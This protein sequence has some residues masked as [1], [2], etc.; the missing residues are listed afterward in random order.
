LD[1]KSR[2]RRNDLEN[3]LSPLKEKLITHPSFSF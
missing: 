2:L 1:S 3:K